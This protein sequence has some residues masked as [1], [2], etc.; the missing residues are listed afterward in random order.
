MRRGHEL[1][2]I[3]DLSKTA[4]IECHGTGTA[5]GDPI[6]AA[7]VAN[8]FGEHGIYIG[9]VKPNLGHS[10]GA[11]GLSSIIKMT[12]ALE[13]K[14]IPPN[15]NFTVPNPKIPWKASKLHVPVVP[16][17]WPQDWD[18][19]VGVNSFGVGGSNAHVILGSAESFGI[20]KTLSQ[21]SVKLHRTLLVPR[22]LV[23]SAKHPQ[24]LTR[25]IADHQSFH[26]SNPDS[27]ADMS[28][29][30]AMKR[31]VL[32]HCA[33][34]VTDGEDSWEPSVMHQ[35]SERQA[36]QLAFAFTGQGAQW[37][38]MGA[39]LLTNV[40]VFRK[41]IEELD[42]LLSTVPEPPAWKLSDLL[43]APRKSSRLVEAE[44]SQPCCTALQIALVDVLCQYGIKPNAV[45]GHSSGE[46]AAAY[47]CGAVTAR[48]A[49]SI[50]YYRGKVMAELDTT[51][52]PGAMAAVGLSP[53]EVV[54]YLRPGVSVGCENSPRSTTLT[55]DRNILELVGKEIKA[56]LPDILVRMLNVDRAYHSNQ[57]GPATSRYLELMA[58]VNIC[59]L[60][61]Q[62]PLFSSVTCSIVARGK[63]LG[64]AYW[65]QNLV[66]PVKFS[67]AVSSVVTNIVSRKL[68]VEIGPHSAL[69]GPI[70]QTLQGLKS[71]DDYLSLQT[72]GSDSHKEFLRSI[73][74]M[75]LRNC[76]VDLEN[77]TG[78]G[79]FIPALPL[80]PWHYDEP[81]WAESRLS[82]EWRLR[83]FPHHDI[84]GSRVIESTDQNPSWRNILR[85]DVVPW[86]KEHEI[87]GEVLL[88]AVG[89]VCMAGEAIRQLTKSTTFTARRIHIKAALVMQQ[90]QDR[91]VITQL[92][93]MPITSTLDSK[94]Y[95]FAVYSLEN[96]VW[97]KHS[98]GQIMA[99]SEYPRETPVIASLP[100][101]LSRRAWYR[102]FKE[103]GLDY[104]PRFMG[105]NDMT[106]HP[107]EC[108][109]VANITNDIRE[110]ETA[111]AVHP[112][113]MDT[114][115]QA[116]GPAT[117][118]GLPRRFQSFSI[119]TYIHE[120][121][122]CPPLANK[123][124]I[125]ATT[126]QEPK[127]ALSG[128][129]VAVS[130]GQLV[131]DLQGLQMSR[132]GSIQ[133]A[134]IDPH[135]AV[136][137]EWQEDLNF[138]DV[139][140]LIRQKHDRTSLHLKLDEFFFACIKET[141]QQLRGIQPTKDYLSHY[142][143]WLEAFPFQYSSY[144][145]PTGQGYVIIEKLYADLQ[146]TAAS[147]AATAI[148]KITKHCREIF[149]GEVE[150]LDLLMEDNVLH[151]LYDYIQNSECATFLGL[152]AHRKPNMRVLEI[153]AGTGGTTATVLPSLRSSYGERM[154][155][156][157]TFTDISSGFFPAAKERF[158]DFDGLEYKVLDI[159]Q[160]PIEQ[161]FQA[162]EFDLIIAC[163]VLHATPSLR[164]TLS[165]VRKLLHPQGRLL[166]QELSPDTKW[167]NFVM[168]V[169][170]G[171]WLGAPD[172]RF[173][174]PYISAARWIEEL[175]ATG[176]T[177]IDACSHDGYLN[178]NI[179]ARPTMKHPGPRNVTLLYFDK[180]GKFKEKIS[181]CLEAGGFEVDFLC[182]DDKTT[183]P[184]PQ[185]DIIS[186]LDL[187]GPFFHDITESR[188][189]N[190]KSIL[191]QLQGSRI[192]WVTR[193]CQ[194]ACTDPRYA[195]VIG[196][197]RV[198]RTEMAL[199]LATLEL[200]KLNDAN[201]G[202]IPAIFRDLQ[203]CVLEENV[204]PTSEWALVDGKLLISRY[205]YI[206]VADELK[207]KKTDSAVR[208]LELSKPG[209]LN[210]LHWK[211]VELAEL[212]DDYVQVDG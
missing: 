67:T 176:F 202:F 209:L 182:L 201:F 12:L 5:V 49:I 28:Y 36:P 142:Q 4:M 119:P 139:A 106:S 152:A 114:L 100:R 2:G 98:S 205:H 58:S 108:K 145:L 138:L 26:I 55:G 20:H 162:E 101:V 32:S 183:S 94:W 170:P 200:E 137:L 199:N 198:L 61:P 172:G 80:Y 184:R 136:E 147:E 150:A 48:E 37:A 115:L 9:S 133:D 193:S 7:A 179:I 132:L 93:V 129:I 30:L 19:V 31:E 82:R 42:T 35:R 59:P 52:A 122:V 57:M 53:E 51:K 154:F 111:Y 34:C 140:S 56:A 77:I 14:I 195:M 79:E 158:K 109:L 185:Q 186:I 168:G 165:H 180:E 166:L 177:R 68:F 206:R 112:V 78:K 156:S 174:E 73:G 83:E 194:V 38:Q 87:A 155:L 18:E 29:S 210:S 120:I 107:V 128:N 105:L 203:D 24:A 134:D 13:K 39:K 143:E 86:I 63:D 113:T 188:F 204:S 95:Y 116:L 88:P 192:L 212:A 189:V 97:T 144:N 62:I 74:E 10:E 70:R 69:A 40:E 90:G 22:L 196:V 16:M 141:T 65:V 208:K 23:F 187:E 75:W 117:C 146:Q 121:Y 15:I 54:P 103:M 11:S 102:K 6:E 135:A 50:A 43:S 175:Q 211:E 72:R 21:P 91:E 153:G 33:F 171:W 173:T 125:Q 85:S 84:L 118:N 190:F 178:N 25:M 8:I 66:S 64:P 81:L 27:L 197:A 89:Y 45:L 191:S 47:A 123:M 60:D 181:K 148:Y 44:I 161:G 110:D 1:A 163:N 167:I 149:R 157:Y 46:I 99:G 76:P 207:K 71:D 151:R 130:E 3:S 96:G 92:Q 131:I 159:S 127:A 164:R 124:V 41:S 17:P 126:D 104:G 160:D 169:L